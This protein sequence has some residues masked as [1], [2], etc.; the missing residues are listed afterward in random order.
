MKV[1]ISQPTYLP[2]I[3]YFDLVDQ[4]DAFVFLDSVQFEKQSWQQRNRIKAPRELQWITVPVVFRGRFGQLINEVEIREPEFWRKHLRAIELNYRRTPFF[5]RYF[6]DLSSLLR[7]FS[8][9]SLLVDLNIMLIEW[10]MKVMG[11]QTPLVRSS[12]IGEK[13]KRGQLLINLCQS[14]G[15]K[16]YLSPLGSAV[17]LLEQT[18]AFSGK[19]IEVLFQ[20]YEHPVYRQQFPPFCSHASVLDLLFNEGDG[21]LEILRS[22]RSSPWLPEEVES[23]AGAK[24]EKA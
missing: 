20:H 6:S 4:V 9:D 2:W 16:S 23:L 21:S 15:A 1:A 17:Y 18:P 7:L 5:D 19:G 13:G 22:G 14:L 12:V 3:G 11:I 24:M 10:A 8:K